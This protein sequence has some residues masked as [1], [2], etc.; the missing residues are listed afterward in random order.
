MTPPPAPFRGFPAVGL[1]P[2][3]RRRRRARRTGRDRAGRFPPPLFP[4][5]RAAPQPGGAPAAPIRRPIRG[6]SPRTTRSC[7][8]PATWPPPGWT[9]RPSTRRACRRAGSHWRTWVPPCCYDVYRQAGHSPGLRALYDSAVRRLAEIHARGT[10]GFDPRRTHNPDWDAAFARRQESGYFQRSFLRGWLDW[11]P[12]GL[13]A[14]LDRLAQAVAACW[15]PWFLY[16]DF[17]SQNIAV[18]GERLRFFDFQGARR[19]PR[20]YDLASLLGDP[21]VELPA[22][23]AGAAGRRRISKRPRPWIRPSTPGGSSGDWPVVAAHRLMQALGAYGHLIHGGGQAV[24][25]GAHP[26]G[27]P[28]DEPGCW[29]SRPPCGTAR[30]VALRGQTAGPGGPPARRRT[31]RVPLRRSPAADEGRVRTLS[32][33]GRILG[34][35]SDCRRRNAPSGTGA[36]PAAGEIRPHPCPAGSRDSFFPYQGVTYESMQSPLRRLPLWIAIALVAAF[37]LPAAAADDHAGRAADALPRRPRRH[38]RLRPRRGH[39]DRPRR[40]R[41]GAPPHHPRG[42]GALPQVLARRRPSPSPPSTTATPT[43]TS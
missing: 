10:P 17:Q 23:V 30:S 39:L 12:D 15:E 13:D 20:Q 8:W 41:A 35:F 9:C 38:R 14:D 32:S 27:P 29:S 2:A 5:R 4:A 22:G 16:R 25:P 34:L 43:S 6:A 37:A 7:T 19:G 28:P 21:Y 31:W 42:R 1:P 40:R 18:Q 11:E 3:I 33:R 36:L 24:V 26:R